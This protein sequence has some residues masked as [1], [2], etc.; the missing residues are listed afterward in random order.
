MHDAWRLTFVYDGEDYRLRSIRRLEKRIPR[1]V[2][3][4]AG[5]RRSVELRGREKAVL[6]RRGI[7][8]LVPETVEYPTGD[9][10]RP[11]GRVPV[12]G[13]RQVSVVVPDLPEAASVA[14]VEHERPAEGRKRARAAEG[15]RRDLL[16]VDLPR[17]E[18]AR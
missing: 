14:N 16:V 15:E 18:D 5:P 4:G 9:P 2:G 13:P 8:H 11:L 12:T 10:A 1:A 7:D 17:R 3:E 6:F